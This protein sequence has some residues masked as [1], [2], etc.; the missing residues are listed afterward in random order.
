[1]QSS[2]CVGGSEQEAPPATASYHAAGFADFYKELLAPSLPTECQAAL[3]WQVRDGD[4]GA[5]EGDVVVLD[6]CCGS[7][8]VGLALLTRHDAWTAGHE[9]NA[10]GD[11]A[12][13]RDSAASE[14]EDGEAGSEAAT[15]TARTLSSSVARSAERMTV[16][17]ADPSLADSEVLL[18]TDCTWGS[19]PN[20]VRCLREAGMRVQIAPD[21]LG[22]LSKVE[23]AICWNPP[24]GLL[25][26]CPNLKAIQSMGAGVDSLL[27]LDLPTHVPLL[28]VIDPAPARAPRPEPLPLLAETRPPTHIHT[29]T[30]PLMT[31]RMATWVLW[32]VIN[33][34][35][36][37][38]E[39][40][41]AQAAGRWDKSIENYRNVDNAEL[42]VGVM[43]L[44]VMGGAVADT[45][46][47]LGYAVSAWTRMPRAAPPPG[48]ACHAGRAALRDFAAGVDVLVCLLPLTPETQGILNAEL[49]GWLPRGAAVINAARGKHLVEADLL[50]AL[51]SGHLRSAT[52]DVFDPEP[53]PPASRLWAH[54]RVRIF[55]HV[56]A[57]TN[58]ETA[59]AQMLENRAAVLSRRPVPQQLVADWEAG[60]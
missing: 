31:E 51:D 24:P 7:G 12:A 40:A 15:C 45:L 11:A 8:R 25:Q 2:P 60:Y 14:N 28:R 9:R 44:G 20:W 36:R 34:Q 33:A 3:P 55:P 16:W 35:R 58:I 46:L 54:P 4:Q 17:R 50:A 52:L 57:M 53:L 22:D 21:E 19:T 48:V 37:C 27:G 18:A 49:F 56:S 5:G 30:Q 13:H 23:F 41:A 26:Q 42:R 10:R 1:M 32:A 6:L 39:Y 38:D 47:R 59:V 43:G 29:H